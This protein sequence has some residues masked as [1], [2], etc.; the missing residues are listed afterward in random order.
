V[1][2]WADHTG[3]LELEIEAASEAA[4]FE[5]A[6]A[7]VG[8]LLGEAAT[9]ESGADARD[10]EAEVVHA[11]RVRAPDRAALLAEW[12]AELVF[13]G[14]TEDLVPMAIRSLELDGR[15]LQATV[16]GRAGQPPHLVKAVTYHDLRFEPEG[17]GWS[18]RVVLDV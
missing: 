12:I 15:E 11:V 3:E 7:A 5:D 6:L 4:V 17:D 2:R 14:E 18:A 1:Y 8:E 10:G 16:A 9:D 13:L